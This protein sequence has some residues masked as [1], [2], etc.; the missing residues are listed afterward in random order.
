MVEG[1]RWPF[2]II[3]IGIIHMVPHRQ[4]R[5]NESSTIV[6][7]NIALVHAPRHAVYAVHHLPSGVSR[8][9]DLLHS[10]R[11]LAHLEDCTIVAIELE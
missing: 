11:S 7:S 9:H 1:S 4:L 5:K 10:F 2:Q 3:E 6:A 8:L